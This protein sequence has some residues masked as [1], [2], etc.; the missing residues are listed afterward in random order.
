MSDYDAIVIGA[1]HDGLTSE[2]AL[3]DTGVPKTP[4]LQFPL[5]DSDPLLHGNEMIHMNDREVGYILA[6][7]CGHTLGGAVG[8]GFAELG[9]PRRSI[10]SRS[11]R[12]PA[13]D[14]ELSHAEEVLTIR[15]GLLDLLPPLPGFAVRDRAGVDGDGQA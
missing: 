8:I 11:G 1:G 3:K 15:H 7:A 6:G 2:A 13:D 10:R 4:M 14:C 12:H 9:G 5:Q